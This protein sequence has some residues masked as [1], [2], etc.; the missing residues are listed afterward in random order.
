MVEGIETCVGNDRRLPPRAI[1]E[2]VEGAAGSE[3]ALVPV[4]DFR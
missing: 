2:A 4:S 1:R 3:F